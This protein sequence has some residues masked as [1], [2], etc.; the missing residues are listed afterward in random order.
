MAQTESTP[1]L[2]P[3]KYI[4]QSFRFHLLIIYRIALTFWQQSFGDLHTDE[5]AA[6]CIWGFEERFFCLKVWGEILGPF[7]SEP[8]GSVGTSVNCI[9]IN[10]LP[11]L[12]NMSLGPK[13]NRWKKLNK[14]QA[15]AAAVLLDIWRE[16]T[17]IAKVETYHW[18]IM[19]GLVFYVFR[20]IEFSLT[21][22]WSV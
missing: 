14:H 5:W 9:P 12:F 13:E 21:W 22:R 10:G 18:G 2:S 16:N 19:G 15:I 4:V 1:L 8:T 7:Q 17:I 3:I 11:L 20:M 6:P